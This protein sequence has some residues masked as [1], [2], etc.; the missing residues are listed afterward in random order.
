ME[1]SLP[2]SPRVGPIIV[3]R[4]VSWIDVRGDASDQHAPAGLSVVVELVDLEGGRSVAQVICERRMWRNLDQHGA[5]VEGVVHRQDDRPQVVAV[6][7]PADF[8]LGEKLQTSRFA[9]LPQVTWEPPFVSAQVA[10]SDLHFL[11]RRA[12][13][14]PRQP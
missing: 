9:K 13:P 12:A 10:L 7:D 3:G 1:C 2:F 4:E 8:M 5:L 11:K 6:G 14:D